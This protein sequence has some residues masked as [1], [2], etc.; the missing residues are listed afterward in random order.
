[1]STLVNR[2]FQSLRRGCDRL[3]HVA[4]KKGEGGRGKGAGGRGKG[5][6]G[7]GIGEVDRLFQLPLSEFTPARNALATTLKKS[8]DTDEAGRVKALPKPSLSAWVANQ[9]YWRDRLAFDRLLAAGNQFR[10]A[11]AAQ[12]AGKSTDVRAP[13]DARREALSD[14]TRRAADVLRESGHP[15]SPE[16][17]RRIM[18]TLEALATYGGQ[19]ASAPAGRLTS[20]VD[21]PGFEALAA[22]IPRGGTSARQ[23]G[24]PPRV[25]P[26]SQPRTE[27]SAK[28]GGSAEEKARR[29][30]AEH[31]QKQAAA[32]KALLDAERD[33]KDTKRAAEQARAAMKK[34]AANAKE[35]ESVRA[36][37]ETRFEKA[38]A[39]ADVARQEARRVAS[40]AEE[41]AQAVDDAER[42]VA[43][44]REKLKNTERT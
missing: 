11:Q 21:P 7:S 9:L 2:V 30:D 40:Q 15:A 14:M 18:T 37:L 5:A 12:L 41:A 8:G 20:D 4:H 22:L 24:A 44:A 38:S 19:T 13:L 43:S 23:G 25:I 39:E 16:T 3:G 33:L 36:A 27:T 1:M 10:T 6:A 31:R 42:G 29:R 17:M 34:A 28:Q 35:M 26:F 32:R